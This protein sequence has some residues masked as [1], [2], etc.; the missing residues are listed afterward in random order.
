M[1]PFFFQYQKPF[2]TK[3]QNLLYFTKPRITVASTDSAD[4]LQDDATIS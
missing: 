2:L 4:L 3:N 1:L